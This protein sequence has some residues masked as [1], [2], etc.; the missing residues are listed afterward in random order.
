MNESLLYRVKKIENWEH[1]LERKER[2]RSDE[3]EQERSDEEERVRSDEEERGRFDDDECVRSDDDERERSDKGE[4]ER[5]N[6]KEREGYDD[7]EWERYDN[8]KLE[9]YDDKGSDEKDS[10]VKFAEDDYES[11]LLNLHSLFSYLNHAVI[12][13]VWSVTTIEQNKEHFVV[14]YGNTNHLCT[15]MWLVTRRLVC[16]H[17]F[18][19]DV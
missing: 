7:Y 2:E 18:F 15:C 6:K 13:E 1:L 3:E 19:S 10:K 16:R 5:S 14:L 4:W 8:D 12:H 9:R 11:K 17:F